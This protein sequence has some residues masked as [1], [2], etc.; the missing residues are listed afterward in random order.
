MTRIFRIG[1]H[2]V[3]QRQS[4]G[5]PRLGRL[6][7]RATPCQEV[8][9]S[10]CWKV[11]RQTHAFAESTFLPLG[12]CLQHA[13][14]ASVDSSRRA[15]TL[16]IIGAALI[17][18]LSPTCHL[19]RVSPRTSRKVPRSEASRLSLG[20]AHQ[21]GGIS[22]APTLNAQ[23]KLRQ[24]CFQRGILRLRGLGG[25]SAQDDMWIY[26]IHRRR[27]RLHYKGARNFV[28]P[29]SP[30][31]MAPPIKQAGSMLSRNLPKK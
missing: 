18:S 16:R 26:A 19:E 13:H 21:P 9:A 30:R 4:A 20:M 5:A 17:P 23:P 29:A 3:I 14:P 8:V 6:R 22:F 25:R 2:P 27:G 12:S 31:A 24:P 11:D 15:P 28:A 7:P 10:R 1:L